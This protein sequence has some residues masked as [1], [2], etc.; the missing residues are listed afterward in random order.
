[1]IMI[2]CFKHIINQYVFENACFPTAIWQQEAHI[3][4]KDTL[5]NLDHIS[6]AL[7][8][9]RTVKLPTVQDF[10]HDDA[11]VIHNTLQ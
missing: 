7:G 11:Q 5:D 1:M 6:Q 4:T 8:Q 10:L 2:V 3:S 9:L